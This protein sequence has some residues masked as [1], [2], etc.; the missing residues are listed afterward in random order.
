MTNDH[1]VNIIEAADEYTQ[2]AREER[3]TDDGFQPLDISIYR[4]QGN[5]ENYRI[6]FL[7]TCGGPHVE[8][9]VDENGRA[10]FSHSWGKNGDA[11]DAA[12]RKECDFSSDD[13]EFWEQLAE[14]YAEMM[15]AE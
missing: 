3:E 5:P 13:Q 6:E 12:D 15:T 2:S 11:E 1:R 9:T 8:V 14:E 10:A 7:L 4:K